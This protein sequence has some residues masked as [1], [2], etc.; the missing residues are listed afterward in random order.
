METPGALFSRAIAKCAAASM[1]M[2]AVV[3]NVSMRRSPIAEPH[4][5]TG[6]LDDTPDCQCGGQGT[7]EQA[8][9]RD[10]REVDEQ[11]PCS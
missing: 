1:D 7:G 3:E 8:G 4:C 9:L 10:R 2:L 6:V 11:T 5:S